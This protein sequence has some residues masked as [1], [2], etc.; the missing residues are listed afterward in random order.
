MR[1]KL[2]LLALAAGIVGIMAFAT[3]PAA[4]AQC[5]DGDSRERTPIVVNEDGTTSGG[6]PTGSDYL[7]GPAGPSGTIVYSDG[8]S[9]AGVTG[10]AG[11]IEVSD[12]NGGQIDGASSGGELDGSLSTGGLC[13]NDVSAP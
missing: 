8:G 3:G 6:D 12:D 4:Y 7:A 5:S 2:S 1:K 13:L 11:Y 9:Y 10:S